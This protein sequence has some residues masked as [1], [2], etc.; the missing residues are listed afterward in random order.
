VAQSFAVAQFVAVILVS[1][2]ILT[3]P[4]VIVQSVGICLILIG[5]AVVG[6]ER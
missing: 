4:I 2:I 6:L 1:W 5:V 3:E